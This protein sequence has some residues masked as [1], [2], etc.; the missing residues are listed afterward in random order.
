MISCDGGS[1]A[2]LSTV[3]AAGRRILELGATDAAVV[4]DPVD[5]ARP[6]KR[7][8]AIAELDLPVRR[9]G[10]FAVGEGLLHRLLLL[11]NALF[12]PLAD[13]ADVEEDGVA[14]R[15]DFRRRSGARRTNSNSKANERQSQADSPHHRQ[16][17]ER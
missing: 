13:K 15:R 8:A 11:L 4:T 1:S 17:P 7:C 14:K 5:P 12:L 3:L 10:F 9:L 6:A 16:T 2:H